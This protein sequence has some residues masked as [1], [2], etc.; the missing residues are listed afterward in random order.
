MHSSKA[1][2]AA[3]GATLSHEPLKL[4][5]L[6]THRIHA[7]ALKELLDGDEPGGLEDDSEALEHEPA[8]DKLELAV[9]G[10]RDAERDGDDDDGLALVEGVEAHGDRHEED[11][12]RS[13]GLEPAR[14]RSRRSVGESLR[15]HELAR[16]HIW[17]NGIERVKYAKLLKMREAENRAPMGT[18]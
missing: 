4:R 1:R 13:E 12:D 8:K 3:S 15:R 6:P 9:R 17:M 10:E 7:H 5:F 18:I 16:P 2:R 14:W 11:G